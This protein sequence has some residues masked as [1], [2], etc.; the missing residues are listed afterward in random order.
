[1]I[2]TDL[3]NSRIRLVA[4]FRFYRASA[5]FAKEVAERLECARLV[6]AVDMAALSMTSRVWSILAFDPGRL[7]TKEKNESGDKSRALQMLAQVARLL[8]RAL[9]NWPQRRDLLNR[10]ASLTVSRSSLSLESILR[11]RLK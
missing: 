3:P 9:M 11:A 8:W 4:C 6:G 1:M 2:A 10:K 5:N 7:G